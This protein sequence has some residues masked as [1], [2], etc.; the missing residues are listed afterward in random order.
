MARKN[1]LE[2]Q[3]FL[4]WQTK[5]FS[6]GNSQIFFNGA[7]EH[8]RMATVSQMAMVS[9]MANENIFTW[10]VRIS[11]MAR[12][13]ILEWQWSLEK[14]TKTFSHGY[15]QNLSN[16]KGRYECLATS[17]SKENLLNLMF[18]QLA[19]SFSKELWEY[20][21]WSTGFLDYEVN[22]RT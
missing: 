19:R 14:Q 8:S 9:R 10:Q 4:E 13:G 21:Y 17:L 16:G 6:H 15:S 3:W 22:K 5:M 18:F 7:G 2:W 20:V 12:E 11:S 1:V